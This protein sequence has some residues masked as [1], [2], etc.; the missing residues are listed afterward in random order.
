MAIGGQH[1]ENE[2]RA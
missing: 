2:L 1:F